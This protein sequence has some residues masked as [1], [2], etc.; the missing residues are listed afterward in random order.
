MFEL[1]SNIKEK[2]KEIAQEM[3]Q[4]NKTTQSIPFGG[5]LKD[6]TLVVSKNKEEVNFVYHFELEGTTFYVGEKK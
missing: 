4:N 5:S 3:L 2:A 1:S 6:S